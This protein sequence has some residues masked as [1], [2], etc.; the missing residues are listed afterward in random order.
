V[1]DGVGQLHRGELSLCRGE[2]PCTE[3]AFAGRYTTSAKNQ[4]SF[5]VD[6]L[7]EAKFCFVFTGSGIVNL[8]LEGAKGLH[9]TGIMEST[10]DASS[11]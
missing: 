6:I 3:Q 8:E 10:K 9:A 2:G 5:W 7:S 1:A 11:E 4:G